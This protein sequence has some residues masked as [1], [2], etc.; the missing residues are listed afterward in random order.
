MRKL[1]LATVAAVIVTAP[2]SVTVKASDADSAY[3][4]ASTTAASVPSN[5][6]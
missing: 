2:M 6:R 3:M 5:G 4:N 1:I